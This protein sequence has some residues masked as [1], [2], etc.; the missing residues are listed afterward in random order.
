MLRAVTQRLPAAIVIPQRAVRD[1]QGLTQVAVVGAEDKVAFKNVTL[2]P[3]TGSNYVVTA[4]LTAG[5]RV[6]VEGL[7][8]VRDGVVV[9]PVTPAAKEAAAA[10]PPT[11]AN[12]EK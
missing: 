1:L 9:K 11:P 3:A 5:E 8:K 12:P 4:G 7:Q 10:A 2:G 6:L